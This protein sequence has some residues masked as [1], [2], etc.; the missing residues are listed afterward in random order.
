MPLFTNELLKSYRAILGAFS[1]VTAREA[2][3]DKSVT[4]DLNEKNVIYSIYKSSSFDRKGGVITDNSPYKMFY[5]HDVNGTISKILLS[6]VY[7]KSEGNELRLY[8]KSGQFDPDEGDYWFIFTRDG[9]DCPHIGWMKQKDWE[10]FL[11]LDSKEDEI[12]IRFNSLQNIDDEDEEY[13]K[14]VGAAEVKMPVSS[15][16]MKY[17]RDSS[18]ALRALQ[19]SG[20]VCE[21]DPHHKTFMSVTGKLYVECHHLIPVSL[22]QKFPSA[23]LDVEENIV[24]LCPNCHRH[25]HYGIGETKRELLDKL[26]LAR[27][28]G[29]ARRGIKISYENFLGIYM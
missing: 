3:G 17:Q 23:S 12:G 5:V 15:T 13:Q 21:A 26:W 6:V 1:Q 28:D 14:Q 20:Y 8:F 19:T 4:L 10:Q 29:L 27:K 22:L 11:T 16:V 18:V 25:V 7:P 24:T 9:E 2:T